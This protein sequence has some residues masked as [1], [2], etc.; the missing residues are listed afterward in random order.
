MN[1]WRCFF[2]PTHTD[3]YRAILIRKCFAK[4][5]FGGSG[6][7]TQSFKQVTPKLLVIREDSFKTMI[8]STDNG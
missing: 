8:S 6:F 1:G 4:K 2:L 7:H 3:C 5:W